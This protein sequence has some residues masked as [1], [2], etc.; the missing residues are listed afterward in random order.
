MNEQERQSGENRSGASPDRLLLQLLES[1]HEFG[2]RPGYAFSDREILANLRTLQ[3]LLAMVDAVRLRFVADLQTRP[4][5]VPGATPRK[6][7]VSFLTEGLRLSAAQA[8]RDVAA[9]QALVSASPE[10]PLMAAA[11]AEGEVSR[12]H[13]DV[14]VSTLR[15]I[16]KALKTKLVATEVEAPASDDEPMP[17][18][19]EPQPA[20]A[21]GVQVID[22]VLTEQSRQQ[23]PTT[24]ERL[25]RHLVH[26][27]DPDRTE[28]FD[29]DAYQRRTCSISSD[30]A[31]MGVYRLVLDPAT[32]LMVRAAIARW[33]A[34]APA[35]AAEDSSGAATEVTD[36]RSLGQRQADAMAALIL[37][38]D[39]ASDTLTNPTG[40][41]GPDAPGLDGEREAGGVPERAGAADDVSEPTRD[42]PSQPDAATQSAS[43]PA[44]YAAPTQTRVTVIAT[45]DQLEAAFGAMDPAAR[46]A[47]LARMSLAGPGGNYPG[48][49]VDPAVLA[50]LAC[51]SPLR[52]I[53]LDGKG[54]VLHHGRAVRFATAAQKRALAARDGGCCIPGCH[55]PP[56]WSDAHHVIP[57][58]EGGETNIDAMV[59]LC[60]RHHTAHHAG[61]YRI[62]MRDG[63]PW[64]QLPYWQHPGRPWL[65]NT[66]HAIPRIA[67]ETAERITRQTTFPWQI[68]D[69]PPEAA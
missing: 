9:A 45:L 17:D 60:G 24:V 11:L 21:T 1:V 3:S 22:A 25:G 58:A 63:V 46:R 14:A 53:L 69:S 31:G 28:R 12:E 8:N 18:P 7:A 23:P 59:L 36:E 48:A 30:F 61:V 68:G 6:A 39:K 32:H 4:D 64:V 56:E 66:A 55:A 54:A 43:H 52:R 13:V 35:A 42:E 19:A 38:G 47:G 51:D 26:L 29:A 50:R 40:P 5:A 27:L 20:P 62:E 37:N 65:R 44:L 2:E 41:T 16:P 34:P 67:S 49:T 57:W 33:S 10:L 15:R